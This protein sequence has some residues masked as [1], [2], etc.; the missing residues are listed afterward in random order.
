M[1]RLFSPQALHAAARG[2]LRLSD[3]GIFWT[4]IERISLPGGTGL[5]GQSCVEYFIP[6]KLTEK[7]PIV[8]LHGGGQATDFLST[9]DGRPGWVHHFVREGYAVYLVNQPGTGRSSGAPD[10]NGPFAPSN[11]YESTV[12][13]L[14][15]PELV[16]SNYP[17]AQLHTQW[18]GKPEIGDPATD[19]FVASGEPFKLNPIQAQEDVVRGVKEL[20]DHTGP[21]ILVTCSAGAIPG[22]LIVDRAPDK[23]AAIVAVEPFGPPVDGIGP[24]QLPW[25]VTASRMAYDPPAEDAAELHFV[26]N[27]PPSPDR[28][29]CK[30][31]VEPARQLVNLRNIPIGIFTSEASWM[32]LD[33]HGTA[34]FLQQAGCDVDH[35]YFADRG[36]RGNGHLPMLERNSDEAAACLTEWIR[37]KL[38]AA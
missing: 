31:Q 4:G 21:A 23:V 16:P 11:S 19:A 2:A 7:Y 24:M 18:P 30:L 36:V 20:L 27:D 22:W 34:A 10:L 12:A 13:M 38:S 15:A 3:F 8:F 29:A 33:N 37:A 26:L 9:A 35:V 32:V 17:Q 5:R 1:T 6:E 28:V 25:G 14:V